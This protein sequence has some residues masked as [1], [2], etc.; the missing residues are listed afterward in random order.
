[1][2]EDSK[3]RKERRCSRAWSP[4]DVGVRMR[5]TILVG[6]LDQPWL[7]STAVSDPHCG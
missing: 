3:M 5:L 1:M 4:N 2:Q 7:M 6:S